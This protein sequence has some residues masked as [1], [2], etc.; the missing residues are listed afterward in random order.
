[1]RIYWIPINNSKVVLCESYCIF[2]LLLVKSLYIIFTYSIGA[3][4]CLNF[5]CCRKFFL[6]K[7]TEVMLIPSK[8]FGIDIAEERLKNFG[9]C[10]VELYEKEEKRCKNNA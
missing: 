4:R 8:I 5:Y 9:S 3:K 2:L 6:Q 7:F 10:Y 1:M